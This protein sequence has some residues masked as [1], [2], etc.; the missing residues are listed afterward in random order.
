MKLYREV[1]TLKEGVMMAHHIDTNRKWHKENSGKW[2]PNTLIEPIEITEEEI[3]GI[4]N[5]NLQAY[6]ERQE[7]IYADIFGIIE[8]AK[9]IL[10]KLK[11]G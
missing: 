2:P 1:D 7:P 4:L 3:I 10:S 6:T 5:E 9:A 8:S 11:N